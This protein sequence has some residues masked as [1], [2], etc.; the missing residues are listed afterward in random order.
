VTQ[1]RKPPCGR[2]CG[3]IKTGIETPFIIGGDDRLD[4]L[5]FTALDNEKANDDG[6]HPATHP[7]K[8]VCNSARVSFGGLS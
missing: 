5:L 4:L 8:N 3:A 6:A 2:A 1:L 7:F